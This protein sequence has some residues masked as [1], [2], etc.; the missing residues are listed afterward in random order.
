MR[1][2]NACFPSKN[3]PCLNVPVEGNKCAKH[4]KTAKMGQL[5]L[6]IMENPAFI[7]CTEARRGGKFWQFRSPDTPALSVLFIH[8]L[9][10][11]LAAKLRYP[12]RCSG[13][14]SEQIQIR[15][16]QCWGSSNGETRIQQNR[17]RPIKSRLVSMSQFRGNM[18]KADSKLWQ[19]WHSSPAPEARRRA[20]VAI[21]AIQISC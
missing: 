15:H 18:C 20:E 14:F 8:L 11:F 17:F 12:K 1:S 19:F 2:L 7:A 6:Q 4:S 13:P 3:A 10:T 9:T 5:D 21:L 16:L